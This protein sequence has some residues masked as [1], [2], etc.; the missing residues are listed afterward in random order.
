MKPTPTALAFLLALFLFVSPTLPAQAQEPARGNIMI[1]LDGSGSMWARVDNQT[2]IGIAQET[3]AELIDGLPDDVRAGLVAYGHRTEGDCA[4][5]EVLVPLAPVDKARLTEA[6]RSVTPKGRTPITEAVR[7]TAQGLRGPEEAMGGETTILLVSDGKETCAGDPCALVK[8]L[9]ASGINFVMD[10]IGFD[11]TTEERAQL[12][13]M[14]QAGGGTYYPAKDAD[15]FRQAVAQTARKKSLAASRVHVTALRNGQEFRAYVEITN[16]ETGE[17]AHH[18]WTYLGQGLTKN[19]APGEY[20]LTVTDDQAAGNPS[21]SMDILLESGQQREETFDF[22]SGVIRLATRLDDVPIEAF[23]EVFETG[24][25]QAVL[26]TFSDN[27]EHVAEL[28]LPAG[29][30]DIHVSHRKTKDQPERVIKGMRVDYGTE[31][32]MLSAFDSGLLEVSLVLDGREVAGEIHVLD[33]KTKSM[34]W[35]E[36]CAPG[37]PAVFKL[38]SGVY[39]LHVDDVKAEG[40]Y[41]ADDLEHVT[42][43]KGLTVKKTITVVPEQ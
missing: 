35:F 6:V 27:N 38:S 39:T 10:V 13:C 30:Y 34:I 21:Q 2:K 23:I 29:T 43:P 5:V 11:V 41:A 24:G 15:Q 17:L 40:R 22:S 31:I 14:A 16:K 42:L 9:K 32:E 12:E 18:D 37:Q 3:L 33:D 1:I 26:S 20:V 25:D 36:K 28:V 8:E 7:M 4:D 19:L